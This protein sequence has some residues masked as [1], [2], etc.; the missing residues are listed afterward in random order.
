[1][2]VLHRYIIRSFLG[3]FI[4]T[5]FIM[6]FFLLMQFLW[7][8]IDDLVGKGVEWYYIA[9]LLFY[10]T[11]GVVP[12]ALPI[13]VLLSSLMTFG[14][15]GE[16]NELAALKSAGVSLIR[17][18]RPLIVFIILICVG[19][20]FFSN[21]VLP[22]ANLK[23]ESLLRNISAKKPALNIREGVF[24]SGI[25]GYSLKIGEKYGDGNDKL[26]NVYIYDHTS[27]NGN[28]KVI[29]ADKGKMY[30]TPSEDYLVLELEDGVSYEEMMPDDR[31]AQRRYPF[32]RSSFKKSKILFDLTSFQSENLR[33]ERQKSFQMLNTSQLLVAVDSLN[34]ELHEREESMIEALNGRYRFDGI[35]EDSIRVIPNNENVLVNLGDAMERRAVENALR[36]ARAQRAYLTQLAAEYEWRQKVIARHYLEWHKKFSLSFAILVLF[37]IGAPL[38]AIIRKGG[39]GLPVVVSVIIFIIYHTLSFSLEKLGRELVWYP[40][41]AMWA[42]SGIL[43]PIGAMLTYKSATDSALFNSEVY[44]RPFELIINRIKS[45]VAKTK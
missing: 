33:E 37:F 24:Y 21:Y 41:P 5:F 11:A 19:A 34:E 22:V 23:G 39:M 18:M 26:R 36:T 29:V 13:S 38:G 10:T 45:L 43:L 4:A 16:Y 6:V 20:F 32:M 17:I 1:M 40:I 30:M 35:H 12:L 28:G 27:K 2:K 31:K 8:Y 15:L 9:E 3:P 42:A 14:S 7:K 44:L 25:D